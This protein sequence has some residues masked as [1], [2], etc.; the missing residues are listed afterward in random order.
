MKS[1]FTT[2]KCAELYIFRSV[3]DFWRGLDDRR[4]LAAFRLRPLAGAGINVLT[5]A[6]VF[7]Y[8]VSELDRGYR[9]VSFSCWERCCWPF[10]SCISATGC[11][12]PAGKSDRVHRQI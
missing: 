5:I 6:K 9:I 8:D 12:F 1:I 3:D 4:L 11:S 2:W 10:R 7:L